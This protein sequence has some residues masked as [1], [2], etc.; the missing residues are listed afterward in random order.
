MYTVRQL[1]S[2]AGVSARTLRYYDEIDLLPPSSIASNG[3]RYYDD[4][5]LVRLQQ[6]LFY[7]ELGFS[8]DDIRSA[9][10]NPDF[11]MLAALRQHKKS[12]RGRV[13]RL[14][15][16]IQTVDNTILHLKGQ[17]TMSQKQFFA[18][19]SDEKEREYEAE[20][21]RLYDPETVRAS[22]RQWNE[23]TT[24]QKARIMAE[25]NAVYADMISAMQKGPASPE[26]QA[27]VERW[28][29]HLE[30]F[31][32]PK[33][34]QLL[35]LVESY[36]THPDFIANFENIEPGLNVFIRDA[37]HIYVEARKE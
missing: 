34:E 8:L 30:Y 16:L 14:E 36:N 19:F 5:A 33:E 25:G 12:L 20:A 24:E 13:E 37:V 23:Y 3:Y 28:R 2:M 35:G 1:S 7:R 27:S 10:R 32:I 29:R 15:Q 21:A 6:I 4:E 17:S 9:M 26:A 11:N 22:A 18:G 31:W